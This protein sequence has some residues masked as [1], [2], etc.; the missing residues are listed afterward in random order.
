MERKTFVEVDGLLQH[1]PAPRFSRSDQ[2]TP[3]A[4]R[5]AG[6]DTDA[7]LADLGCSASDIAGL[8]EAGVVAG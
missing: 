3:V 7:V 6:E 8:R 4:P 2:Q 1:A 5:V